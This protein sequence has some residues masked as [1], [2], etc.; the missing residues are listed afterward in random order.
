MKPKLRH[1]RLDPKLA[2][3]LRALA[4][5]VGD[6]I[7]Y[8]GFK[9]VQG[10]LW[11]YLYLVQEPLDSRQLAQLLDVSPAL[12]TQ[13]VQVLLKYRVICEAGKGPNGV[14]RFAANPNV[15]EVIGT[16]LAGREL[17]LL[18]KVQKAQAQLAQARPR[19]AAP[20]A[21]DS[22]RVE[23]VGQWI[24]LATLMLKASLQTLGQ[25]EGPFEKPDDFRSFVE[26]LET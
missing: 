1:P 17:V 14:L 2:P 7:E 9:A 20:I 16:V 4:A 19:A 24:A 15:S 25:P 8:W 22:A 3:E 13:S 6:F 21:V 11:C 26:I 5:L 12:V 18:E 23:Q 10:R